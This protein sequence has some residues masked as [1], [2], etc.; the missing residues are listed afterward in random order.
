MKIV[1]TFIVAIVTL[2]LI[3]LSAPALANTFVPSPDSA[4][5]VF[6]G[7]VNLQFIV[8]E[9]QK[10]SF[11]FVCLTLDGKPVT[12]SDGDA[13]LFGYVNVIPQG[14]NSNRSV[15]GFYYIDKPKPAEGCLNAYSGS[16][17]GGAEHLVEVSQL[18]TAQLA[19]GPHTLRIQGFYPTSEPISLDFTFNTTNSSQTKILFHKSITGSQIYGSTATIG[20]EFGRGSEAAPS[21][22]K[23][24][25][26]QKSGSSVWT[27]LPVVN[28]RFTLKTMKLLSR[29]EIQ[30]STTINGQPRTY[31]NVVNLKPKITMSFTNLKVGQSSKT[32][33]KTGGMMSGMCQ[34]EVDDGKYWVTKYALPVRNGV[35]SLTQRYSTKGVYSG[36]VICAGPGFVEGEMAFRKDVVLG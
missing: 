21:T 10:E 5:A 2:G 16:N 3:S 23:V 27:T 26:V 18:D 30:V 14:A 12:K 17:L 11:N 25:V 33:I 31:K 36:K 6:S 22:V 32:I 15:F 29:V 20:G 8:A 9:P 28:N 35:A 34:L 1:K 19:N 4:A 24:R 13:G 7:K